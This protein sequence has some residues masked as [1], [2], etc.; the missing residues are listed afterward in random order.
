[1]PPWAYVLMAGGLW[2]G[3]RRQLKKQS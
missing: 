3:A 2:W 1:M